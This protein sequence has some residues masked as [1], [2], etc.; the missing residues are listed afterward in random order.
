[1]DPRKAECVGHYLYGAGYFSRDE[2]TLALVTGEQTPPHFCMTCPVAQRCEDEHEMRVRALRPAQAERFDRLMR[3][4]VRRGHSP[5]AIALFASTRGQDP[6]ALVASEN[7][8]R[9][10]ADRGREAGLLVH[11]D[12]DPRRH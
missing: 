9:G 5:T 2:N 3:T 8:S 4:G 12:A 1:M 10:H 6:F 7:F 11:S